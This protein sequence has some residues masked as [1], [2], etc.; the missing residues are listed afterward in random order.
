MNKLSN[1][2]LMLLMSATVIFVSSCGDDGEDIIPFGG[3]SITGF[4]VDGVDSSEVT[5]EPGEAFEVSVGYDLDGEEDVSI[6]AFIGDSV[7]FGPA[8]LTEASIN[9]IQTGFTIPEDATEDFAVT[10]ELQDAD[11]AQISNSDF[12]VNLVVDATAET[13]EAVLLEAPVGQSP[14]ERISETFFSA[15]TGEAYSVEEVVAGTEVTSED[16]HFGY[17]FGATN[18]ASIAS[19]NDYPSD[20]YNLGEGGANWGTLNETAFR[21]ISN[22]IFEQSQTNAQV[23]AQFD[24][25]GAGADEGQEING[26]EEGDTYAFRYVEDDETKFGVFR[27]EEIVEGIESTGQITLTVKVESTDE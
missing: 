20:V 25:A 26:L 15:I 2:F 22:D 10:Y 24:I 12:D 17:Y 4:Q 11:G 27:V 9:P 3:A 18:R 21:S 16:I 5:G 13:Y 7:V 19:P 23:A 6:V 1:Y 14:G 8:P